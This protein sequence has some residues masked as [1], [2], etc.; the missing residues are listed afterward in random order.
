MSGQAIRPSQFVLTYGVGSVLEAPNGPRII[1]SFKDWG[2]IFG[3]SQASLSLG[4]YE[5]GDD[6][7]RALLG[8]GRIFRLPTNADM[9][10]PDERVLF[11]TGRFPRWA[12]C[13]DHRILYELTSRGTT[14]C[15]SCDPRKEAQHE[16]IRFVRACPRGHLD[17][18]NW[19]RIIHRRNPTCEG[20]L[21]DWIERG[22]TLRD[23]T[24]RCRNCGSEATLQD[25]YN[26]TWSC[27]GRFPESG[28]EE[29]CNEQAYVV[30]RNASNL[31]I[32]E[33]VSALT[34]PPRTTPLH[35]LFGNPRI[36][37]ILASE[38]AWTK[39]KLLTKLR[40]AAKHIP[41]INPITIETIEHS[42]EGEILSAIDDVLEPPEQ[43]LTIVDVKNKELQALQNAAVNGAPPRPYPEPQ[44]F[45]VDKNA[46]TRAVLSTNL[47]LRVTPVKRLR[48][49][50]AQRGYRRPIR[51]PT[52]TVVET[53]YMDGQDRWYAG[54]ELHGEGIFIDLAAERVLDLTNVKSAQAWLTE[55]G[56]SKNY[57]FH[58]TF[59]WWHTLSHRLI[60]AL[61]IDSGYSSASIRERVYIAID[62]K[63]GNAYG[64][65]LLYTSQ[66]GGDG[67]LG[68]LIAL[69]PKFAMIVS[70]AL[71]N[72]HSCSNDP[73]CA[74][75]RLRSGRLNAAACYACLLVS[76][77]SCEFGN[78]YLDR[79]LLR[80]TVP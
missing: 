37:S 61:S 24:I 50:N 53:F 10:I 56:K 74:E 2:R 80:E 69:V 43:D 35:R 29:T 47:D 7:V 34:I 20:R 51:G 64:G 6:N 55:L 27:S 11:K 3:T 48:V 44:D 15:P 13:Q 18:V 23:I 39:E 66:H 65:I 36:F 17:D 12:L 79:N 71:R 63:S 78:S 76:E 57:S 73:L 40:T 25:V 52:S 38:S 22:S 72:L 42:S 31:R 77:T 60:K 14:R 62:K 30:L 68:G 70:A 9:Q 5:I 59:V 46:V 67:S 33:V 19:K 45:E 4:R 26:G 58:P 41:A 49:V 32:P 21:F 54:A 75:Q 8:G 28:Y 1:L 16:A